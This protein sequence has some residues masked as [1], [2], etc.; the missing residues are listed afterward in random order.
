MQGNDSAGLTKMCLVGGARPYKT[1]VSLAKLLID[2]WMWY[3]SA[4][5]ILL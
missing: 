4:Y 5:H 3:T 2:V 1:N